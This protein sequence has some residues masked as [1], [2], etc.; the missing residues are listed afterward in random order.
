MRA[1][2]DA[3][4][5]CALQELGWRGVPFTWDKQQGNMNVKARLDRAFLNQRF[6]DLFEFSSVKHI[7]SVESD[8]CFVLAELKAT[9]ATGWSRAQRTFRYENVWQSHPDYDDMV[10]RLWRT[11]AGQ[12]GL[13]GPVDALSELQNDL[14][15]WGQR[16]FGNL[17]KKVRKLQ[18]RLDR[19]RSASL[20][21][22]P[23]EEENQWHHSCEKLFGKRK[24][25]LSNDLV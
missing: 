2:R 25:G 19:L 14:G 7:S 24:Y 13:Q 18:Q 20:G 6:L 8:H 11:G 3:V 21:R 5:D 1:F 22:G 23:T 12:G 4:V 17:V 10:R 9:M 15:S 16:E